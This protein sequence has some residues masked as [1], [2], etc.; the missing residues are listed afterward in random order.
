ML[1]RFASGV[2][3]FNDR[4]KPTV[5]RMK[6]MVN[7]NAVNNH[8]AMPQAVV[9]PKGCKIKSSMQRLEQQQDELFEL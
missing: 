5:S 7:N 2:D 8:N 3:L 9:V 1:C 6:N 4:R